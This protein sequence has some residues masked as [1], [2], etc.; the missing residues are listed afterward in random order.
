MQN[1]V[2]NSKLI[3]AYNFTNIAVAVLIGKYFNVDIDDIKDALEAYTPNNNR[4]QIIEKATNRLILD[5]YNAN[6]SSM[7]AALTNLNGLKDTNKIAIL[8]DMFE[9]GNDAEIE[10]QAIADY[11]SDLNIN[12]VY[13]I[14]ENF[15]KISTESK[16]VKLFKSFEAFKEALKDISIT[17]S[18]LLIKGSRGMALERTLDFL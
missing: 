6:P 3:G 9:L 2:I 15:N 10:H 1:T 11:A 7:K 12:S 4:S 14:G 18:T 16:T 5:A 17:N 8:G 13:L